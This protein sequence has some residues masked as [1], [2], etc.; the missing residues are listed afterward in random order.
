MPSKNSFSLTGLQRIAAAELRKERIGVRRQGA[1]LVVEQDAIAAFVDG[2]KSVK[3]DLVLTVEGPKVSYSNHDLEVLGVATKWGFKFERHL[4]IGQGEA[5]AL[6]KLFKAAR[7]HLALDRYQ[8]FP[9]L[10]CKA[11]IVSLADQFRVLTEYVDG[12]AQ[13]FKRIVESEFPLATHFG[14]SEDE[15]SSMRRAL[16]RAS[17]PGD[18]V[19]ALRL[20]TY[21]QLHR[22]VEAFETHIEGFDQLRKRFSKRRLV[23]IKMALAG[24]FPSQRYCKLPP[25]KLN[26]ALASV[27]SLK[28]FAE[29]LGLQRPD[30]QAAFMRAVDAHLA[31]VE[32]Y[33][34]ER[35]ATIKAAVANG[36]PVAKL[37]GVAEPVGAALAKQIGRVRT[38]R[39][40]ARLLP[41]YDDAAQQTFIHAA[42]MHERPS[43]KLLDATAPSVGKGLL[44]AF[45]V[46]VATGWTPGKLAN[47]SSQRLDDLADEYDDTTVTK[48]LADIRNDFG[49]STRSDLLALLQSGAAYGKVRMEL[50]EAYGRGDSLAGQIRHAISQGMPFEALVDVSPER[51]AYIRRQIT[52]ASDYRDLRKRGD[53][54]ATFSRQRDAAELADLLDLSEYATFARLRDAA[55][56][57]TPLLSFG[58]L[59]L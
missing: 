54:S 30:Q 17:K 23:H 29:S 24:G 14:I 2:V 39:E 26:A 19:N 58:T 15:A 46:A 27:T 31:L 57:F 38:G 59:S 16:S 49:V 12:E 53:D 5:E 9:T 10:A 56:S 7:T 43:L 18:V 55:K 51:A 13:T 28:P 52:K 33:T 25:D 35:I 20:S 4:P 37:L 48:S 1:T 47:V 32:A 45:R 41:I 42:V 22:F 8:P 6:R 34:P 44:K 40:L 21:A 50:A 36:L 11:R 3:P